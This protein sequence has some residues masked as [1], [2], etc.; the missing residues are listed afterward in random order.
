M[1][2][3][4]FGEGSLRNLHRAH[5]RLILVAGEALRTSRVD[6]G[7]HDGLRTLSEQGDNVAAGV[8]STLDSYHRARHPE[9]GELVPDSDPDGVAWALDLVPYVGGRLRWEW[10][11]TYRVAEAVR[12]AAETHRVPLVWGGAWDQPLSA[13]GADLAAEI[14]AYVDRRR[15]AGKRAFIDGPHFQMIRPT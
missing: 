14:D 12:R 9:T 3:Y 10:E 5:P 15:K 13:L 2:G 8:S 4:R 11:P 1:S 7:V 6:F